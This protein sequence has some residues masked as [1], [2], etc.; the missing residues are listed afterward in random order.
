MNMKSATES[1]SIFKALQG[2]RGGRD[3]QR[4]SGILKLGVSAAA[5]VAKLRDLA[6]Y[7]LIELILPG[8]SLMA[9]LLWL[10]RRQRKA[11]VFQNAEI[12][13]LF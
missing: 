11:A 13:S 6:P 3:A 10:Y 7:A 5:I 1:T 2:T 12:L 9:L 4:T 8:G